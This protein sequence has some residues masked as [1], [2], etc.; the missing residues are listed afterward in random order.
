MQ[1]YPNLSKSID[2]R[3]PDC[4]VDNVRTLSIPLDISNFST[5]NYH[6]FATHLGRHS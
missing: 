6:M 1:L 4:W 3:G 2:V 5:I